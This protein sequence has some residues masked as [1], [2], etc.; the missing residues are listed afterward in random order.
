MMK[1]LTCK[2]A[3]AW[4]R[5]RDQFLLLTHRRPDG[6][7]LGSAA[8]LCLGLRQLGKHAW[9]LENTQTTAKYRTYI[10]GLTADTLPKDATILAVDVA[11]TNLL[12]LEADGISVQ[13]Q[14]CVDHHGSNS[15][16]AAATLLAPDSAACGELVFQLLQAL[17]VR[18]EQRIAEALYV[19]IATDTGC[20]RYSNV[21]ADTFQIVAQL[22]TCG[23]VVY[24]IN[25]TFFETKRLERL[26]LEAHLTD[27][28]SFFA[29]GRIGI[30]TIH[31]AL[32]RQLC[33]IDEDLD[34]I[35]GFAR[36]IEG[37][38][39]G[40][41]IREQPDG[42]CKLSVRTTPDFDASAI[43]ANLGGG[44]HKAAAGATIA[45]SISDAPQSVL[46]AIARC[47]PTLLAE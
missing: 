13:V 32:R 33:L 31:T 12:Q 35:S 38:E 17:D 15:G 10:A 16:Y 27:T 1:T 22:V 39:I 19:A 42:S 26:R 21:T 14:L 18:V 11:D 37:V 47:Y 6:D 46:H 43:C 24:P 25:K 8:A 44:G 7:T 5:A 30:C 29:E 28:I 41:M 3:A 2:E 20:F 40:V 45:Q 4:L 34:G 36:E 23:A 9:L